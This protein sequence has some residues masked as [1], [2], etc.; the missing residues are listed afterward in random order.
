MNIVCES[1]YLVS[2]I[3]VKMTGN[4]KNTRKKGPETEAARMY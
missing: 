2:A 1:S 3:E 4:M